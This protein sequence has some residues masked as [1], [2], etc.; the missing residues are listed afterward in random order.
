MS[1]QVTDKRMCASRSNLLHTRQ[2]PV[3]FEGRLC[4]LLMHNAISLALRT[5]S[6]E[7]SCAYNRGL[8]TRHRVSM[9]SVREGWLP[10]PPAPLPWRLCPYG[11]SNRWI[12]M[13]A[14]S[15]PEFPGSYSPWG[16]DAHSYESYKHQSA[17][18]TLRAR[19]FSRYSVGLSSNPQHRARDNV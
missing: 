3:Y 13:T 11:R 9:R 7:H 12:D 10:Y 4:T 8:M 14:I 17:H 6:L 15:H 16:S 1:H 5:R 18:A 2:S 19:S